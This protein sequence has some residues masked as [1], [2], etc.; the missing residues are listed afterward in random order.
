VAIS[1]RIPNSKATG[2]ATR[3]I[4]AIPIGVRHRRDLGDIA[5]LATSIAKIGLLYPI[6]IDEN[7]RLLAGARR[8]AA[9][10]RR[11]RPLRGRR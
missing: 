3:R 2:G 6:T 1:D 5:G 4:S 11:K 9:C 7:G 10:K 8:P